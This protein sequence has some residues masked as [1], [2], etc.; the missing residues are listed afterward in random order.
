MSV[1]IAKR[2]LP[3]VTISAAPI[4]RGIMLDRILQ[5]LARVVDFL[6]KHVGT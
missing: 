1:T 3:A 2:R 5:L 4:E 6:T